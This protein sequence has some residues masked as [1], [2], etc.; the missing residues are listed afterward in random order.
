MTAIRLAR[1]D[2][3]LSLLIA[4]YLTVCL[5][6]SVAIA[7]LFT[8]LLICCVVVYFAGQY[9]LIDLAIASA[10]PPLAAVA[11]HARRRT[12]L[13]S[14]RITTLCR[15]AGC[16]AATAYGEARRVTGAKWVRPYV[17]RAERIQAAIDLQ[18]RA[19]RRP[20]LAPP[21]DAFDL[22]ALRAL[23]LVSELL[24][25][26]PNTP[27]V[28]GNDTHSGRIA[29]NEAWERN[30]C[31]QV[32]MCAAQPAAPCEVELTGADLFGLSD[33]A[34]A[35]KADPAARAELAARKAASE[36]A[37]KRQETPRKRKPKGAVAAA[38]CGPVDPDDPTAPPIVRSVETDRPQPA[39]AA[40]IEPP[41]LLYV[42]VKNLAQM[43]L[44]TAADEG[45]GKPRYFMVR[46][47][48]FEPYRR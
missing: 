22:S 20:D 26:E 7:P 38:A 36:G 24:R 11:R 9:R 4:L 29:A 27:D 3:F 18:V 2:V 42:R 16:A 35:G 34:L 19:G 45:D 21:A 15:K 44:E 43:R 5:T 23:N 30:P 6:V 28:I 31:G 32:P 10:L 39:P 37:R 41:P 40:P 47:G 1:Q 12:G 25:A 14:Q 48:V 8:A 17:S 33:A 13:T 46:P